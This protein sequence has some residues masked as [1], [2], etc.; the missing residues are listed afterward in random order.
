MDKL[1][2]DFDLGH[3]ISLYHIINKDKARYHAHRKGNGHIVPAMPEVI[4][5][6]RNSDSYGKGINKNEYAEFHFGDVKRKYT[7]KR[8]NQGVFNKKIIRWKNQEPRIRNQELDREFFALQLM[9]VRLHP[10]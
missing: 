6:G 3:N 2:N 7:F 10:D 9:Q 8:V 5:Y 4:V 1:I